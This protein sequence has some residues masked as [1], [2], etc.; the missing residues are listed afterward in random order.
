MSE[1]GP[2]PGMVGLDL[3]DKRELQIAGV[4]MTSVNL[5]A[6]AATM[7]G[8][9]GFEENEVLVTDVLRDVVTF[10]ILRRSVFAHQLTGRGDDV[11]AA[12]RATPGVTLADDARVLSRGVLGWIAA[13]GEDIDA[14]ITAATLKASDIAGRI[15]RRVRVFSTGA[16]VVA[17]D[18]EDTNRATVDRVLSEA[19]YTVSFGG[20]I[21]DD[22]DLIAGSIRRA[23]DEGYG[24]VI[25]T[26]GVGAETK[27]CTVEAVERL[28]PEAATPYLCHFE[29][30]D[31]R[32]A[33]DGVRIAVGELGGA[34]IVCLPGPNEEVSLAL[35]LLRDGLA[36][37]LRRAPLAELIAHR[38]R[39]HLRHRMNWQHV[40]HHHLNTDQETHP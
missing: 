31:R 21:R 23:V 3:L 24:L 10:D 35:P 37:G 19:G 2:P 6:L 7:A 28:D 33:K 18:I 4:T 1:V 9:L 8:V 25:T 27:D 15:A 13:D 36:D 12:L 38:L 29:R 11:L 20:T 40:A 22:L 32:H 39:E 17:G 26:G 16:E 34:V 5:Q 14:A 30:D